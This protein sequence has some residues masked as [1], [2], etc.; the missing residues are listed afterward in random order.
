MLKTS[1]ATFHLFD[2]IPQE[3]KGVVT[4]VFFS[5]SAD[6]FKTAS[7][8]KGLMENN[9]MRHAPRALFCDF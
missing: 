9:C 8:P 6:D 2:T 7:P 4:G 3:E 1:L 5:F